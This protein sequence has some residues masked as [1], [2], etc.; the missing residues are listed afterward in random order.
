MSNSKPFIFG[1][2]VGAAAISLLGFTA[3]GWKFDSKAQAMA[4]NAASAAVQKVLV[5]VCVAQFKADPEVATHTAAFKE[6]KN[7]HPRVEYISLGGWA[8]L[9]GQS[10]PASGLAHSCAQELK[11][12]L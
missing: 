11:E 4:R 5:P 3:F 1:A 2:L 8:T 9:P 7:S 12:T 6:E 10:E